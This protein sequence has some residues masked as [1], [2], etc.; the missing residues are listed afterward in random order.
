VDVL[1]DDRDARS[2]R[3]HRC[4]LVYASRALK[5]AIFSSTSLVL[6]ML[7]AG[8]DGCSKP[9]LSASDAAPVATTVPDAAPINVTPIPT[10]SVA[11]MVNPQNLPAYAGPTGSV[12]GT[13]TV[14]G[15]PAP[16]TPA[17]FKRCPDGQKIYGHAFRNGEPKT[18]GGPRWLADAVVAI[19]GYGDF[20]VQEKDEAEE[21]TI[22]GCGYDRRTVTMTFGQRLEVKNLTKDFWTPKLDPPQTGVM[23]MATPGGDAVKLYPKKPGHYHL[24]DHDR[25]YAV[26]DL[27]AFLHP[28]HTSSKV[29]GTYRIDGVP[30]GKVTVNTSHPSIPNAEAAKDVEIK[31]GVVTRVDLELVYKTPPDAGAQPDAGPP[32]QLR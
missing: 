30:L 26:D 21:V 2:Q 22:Q 1:A 24:I 6:A 11:K 28:L 32:I 16:E 13:I 7:A 15:D 29:G 17:D 25:K 20:Y 14:I 18:P 4:P 27:Y 9:Q 5:A 31:E 12:E 3:G 10:A 8:C 19:T 23:M